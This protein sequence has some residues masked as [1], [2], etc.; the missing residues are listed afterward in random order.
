MV[1]VTPILWYYVIQ[2]PYQATL[3]ALTIMCG[4][5]LLGKQRYFYQAVHF[6]DLEVISK[7][8]GKAQNFFVRCAMFGNPDLLKLSFIAQYPNVFLL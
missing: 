1:D 2:G 7:E 3:L 8:L 5:I 4:S 6:N